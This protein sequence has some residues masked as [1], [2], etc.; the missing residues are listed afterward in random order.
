MGLQDARLKSK[1]QKDNK[2]LYNTGF[3][4]LNRTIEVILEITSSTILLN[5]HYFSSLS[6]LLLVPYKLIPSH[7]LWAELCLPPSPTKKKNHMLRL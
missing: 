2:L 3:Q 7:L 5:K 6:T 4:S 1:P